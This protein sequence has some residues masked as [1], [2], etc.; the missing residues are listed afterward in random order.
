MKGEQILKTQNDYTTLIN[1]SKLEIFMKIRHYCVLCF[2]N[3]FLIISFHL[4]ALAS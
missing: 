3:I 2:C 4:D 1:P